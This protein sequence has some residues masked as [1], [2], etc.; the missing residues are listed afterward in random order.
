MDGNCPGWELSGM[1]IVQDGNCPP[2]GNCPGWE[3]SGMGIIQESKFAMDRIREGSL[4]SHMMYLTYF[5]FPKSN[6]FLWGNVQLHFS[7]NIW[8]LDR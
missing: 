1:G 2:G 5:Y 7:R 3:L 8:R 4:N 6:S